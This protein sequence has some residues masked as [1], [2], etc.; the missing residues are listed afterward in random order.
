[1]EVDL[2]GKLKDLQIGP[3]EVRSPR[4]SSPGGDGISPPGHLLNIAHCA[5]I[6]TCSLYDKRTQDHPADAA[7]Y[8]SG[9]SPVGL[10]RFYLPNY[11][12]TSLADASSHTAAAAVRGIQLKGNTTELCGTVANKGDWPV[13]CW[14][15]PRQ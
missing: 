1:M 8:P 5:Q 14:T 10:K 4:R 15:N 6:L 13:N 9:F 3:W 12:S 11:L 7:R 2:L